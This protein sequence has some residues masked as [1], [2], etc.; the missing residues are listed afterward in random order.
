[1]GLFDKIDNNMIVN[2]LKQF[3]IREETA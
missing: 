3:A 2:A 1:M